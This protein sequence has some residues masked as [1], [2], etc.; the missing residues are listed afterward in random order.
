M[1]IKIVK[2]PNKEDQK[3]QKVADVWSSCWNPLDG[4]DQREVEMMVDQARIGN[5]VRLQCVYALVE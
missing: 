4:L 3:I 1:S 2:N 5:D